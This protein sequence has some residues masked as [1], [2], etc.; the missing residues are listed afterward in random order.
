[1]ALDM[2]VAASPY[3]QPSTLLNSSARFLPC[4]SSQHK[5]NPI[6][7]NLVSA[8]VTVFRSF[9]TDIEKYLKDDDFDM[10]D[11]VDASEEVCQLCQL[12]NRTSHPH[13]D[14]LLKFARSGKCELCHVV[15]LLMYGEMTWPE[16]WQE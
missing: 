9:E 4:T 8:A 6:L 1:M 12:T 7:S 16:A 2:D 13:L 10:D 5:V 15:H 3:P 14:R 11:G